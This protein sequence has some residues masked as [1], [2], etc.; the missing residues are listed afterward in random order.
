[1][2]DRPLVKPRRSKGPRDSDQTLTRD[3]PIVNY[4]SDAKTREFFKSQIGPEF[5]FTYHVNQFR[6]ANEDLTYGN[7]VDEWVVHQFGSGEC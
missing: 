1:M 3:A 5:H 4:Y 6:L 7:L 2:P